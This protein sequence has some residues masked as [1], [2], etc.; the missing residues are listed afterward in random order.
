MTAIGGPIIDLSLGGRYY[1]VSEDAE[2]NRKLGGFENEVPMNGDGTARLVKTRVAWGADGLTLACDDFEDDQQFLQSLADRKGFFEITVGY[3][4][5]SIFQGNGQIVGELA[6]SSK[7]ST[8]TVALQG[9]S[10]FTK[11]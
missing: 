6:F 2:S 11:Q 10:T 8:A 9:T 4:S 1:S 7:Q 3:A 5:G